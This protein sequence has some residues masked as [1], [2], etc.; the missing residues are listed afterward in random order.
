M[1][2]LKSLHILSVLLVL[3]CTAACRT[4]PVTTNTVIG[5]YSYVS[6]DPEAHPTDTS[7]NK[8]VLLA[9]GHFT[10]VEGGESKPIRRT[11]GRWTLTSIRSEP[12]VILADTA[13]PVSINRKTVRLLIDTDVGVWYEKRR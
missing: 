6:E 12:T 2:K 1:R 5:T 4:E 7:D 8:L 11:S 13:F 3:F 10:L 9:D